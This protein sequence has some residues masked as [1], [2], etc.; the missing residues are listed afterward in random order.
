[1]DK[2]IYVWGTGSIGKSV[3]KNGII[4]EIAGWVETSPSM[5]E[6]NGKKVICYKDLSGNEIVV[7]ATIYADEIFESLRKEKTD[8]EN[9]IFFCK[10]K[11]IDCK[12]NLDL[13]KKIFSPKNLQIYLNNYGAYECSFFS[14][15]IAKYQERNTRSSFAIESSNNYPIIT[16]KYDDMGKVDGSFWE[17][18]WVASRIRESMPAEHYDIGSRLN[19]FLSI[20]IAM[21]IPLKVIDVRPFP[22]QIDG[23]ES[24]VDDATELREFADNSIESLSAVSSLEHFGLGRYGDEIDPEACFKCFANIQKRMRG[25]GESLYY[26][27]YR[28]GE[29][30]L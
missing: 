14:E 24:I 8:I 16:D 26:S 15:D 6:M 11:N 29:M 22:V 25:G 23:M 7:V 1:M 4:G 9:Y 20:I 19:G 12:R 10:C 28:K 2:K 13:A 30:L 5:S 17:S 27:T 18:V 21:G 3:V